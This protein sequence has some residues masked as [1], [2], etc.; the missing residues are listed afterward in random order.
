M[1]KTSSQKSKS[2]NYSD[3]VSKN[4]KYK[5]DIN[6][7]PYPENK[8]YTYHFELTLPTYYESVLEKLGYDLKKKYQIIIGALKMR[9]PN[10]SLI[11]YS[12]TKDDVKKFTVD[13]LKFIDN[14]SYTESKSYPDL[15]YFNMLKK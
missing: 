9:F 10:S 11:F 8:L 1:K 7:D 2:W 13:Y 3:I 12:K 15:I 14:Y 5:L 4:K 6:T